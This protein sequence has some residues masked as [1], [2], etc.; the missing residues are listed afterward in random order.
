MSKHDF[1]TEEFADRTSRVRAAIAKAGLDWTGLFHPVSIHWLTGSDAKSYQAFQCLLV[2]AD[3]K[4][5]VM[6]L[7]ESERAEIEA[8][9][10]AGRVE[11]WGGSEPQD[12]LQ[13]FT[14]VVD[15]LGLLKSRV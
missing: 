7:R 8:D 12:P 3:D 9:A 6:I 10:I 15:E 11:T 13:V 14:R 1:T 5:T 4:P 2:S